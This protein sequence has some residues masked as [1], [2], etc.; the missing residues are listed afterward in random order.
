MREEREGRGR[1]KNTGH[2]GAYFNPS[3]M[4]KRKFKGVTNKQWS[5]KTKAHPCVSHALCGECVEQIGPEF[6]KFSALGHRDPGWPRSPSKT[7]EENKPAASQLGSLVLN[8][9]KVRFRRYSNRQC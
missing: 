9:K 4:E 5:Q 2:R 8:V 1:R 6:Y 7:K 3:L